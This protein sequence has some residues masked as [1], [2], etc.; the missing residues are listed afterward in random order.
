[1]SCM[2]MIALWCIAIRGKLGQWLLWL[3]PSTICSGEWLQM[4][5]G[6][7]HRWSHAG[8]IM[9]IFRPYDLMNKNQP[10]DKLLSS[11]VG[12]LPLSHNVYFLFLILFFLFFNNI[13]Q[14][15]ITCGYTLHWFSRINA[16]MPQSEW[17]DCTNI[18]VLA[19]C[20]FVLFCFV[21]YLL[22]KRSASFLK[23]MQL[24]G[25]PGHS[26]SLYLCMCVSRRFGSPRTWSGSEVFT[27]TQV[28]I[29][30]QQ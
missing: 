13:H 17:D 5:K 7:G 30:T 22:P 26:C 1:M 23:V 2:A 21:I 14:E 3:G 10:S 25:S 19:G 8:D 4:T 6:G 27:A 29:D 11:V 18:E 12:I 24:V 20:F 16:Q 15:T 28:Q 9:F